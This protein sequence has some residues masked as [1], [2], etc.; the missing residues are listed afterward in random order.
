MF[1]IFVINLTGWFVSLG[2]LTTL[3]EKFLNIRTMMGY[4]TERSY[5]VPFQHFHHFWF[6]ELKDIC[7]SICFTCKFFRYWSSTMFSINAIYL[8]LLLLFVRFLIYLSSFFLMDCHIS[9]FT[10]IC[11]TVKWCCVCCR[12]F[13]YKSRSLHSNLVTNWL[14]ATQIKVY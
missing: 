4:I 1:A 2:F 3:P 9:R 7:T 11:S 10:Y 13:F 14:I 8:L 5:R 12:I 6:L